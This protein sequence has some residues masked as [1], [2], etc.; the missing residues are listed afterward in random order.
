MRSPELRKPFVACRIALVH[1][2]QV[3]TDSDLRPRAAG[4]VAACSPPLAPYCESLPRRLNS[5]AKHASAVLVEINVVGW[6]LVQVQVRLSSFP[7][8]L[9]DGRLTVGPETA[10]YVATGLCCNLLARTPP[11]VSNLWHVLAVLVDVMLM[12]DELIA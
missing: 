9:R 5:L 12:L 4:N 7:H 11:P 3:L 1:R 2:Q 8:G 6:P 10:I